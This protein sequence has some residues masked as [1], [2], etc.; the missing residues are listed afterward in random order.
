MRLQP[1]HQINMY[2]MY[3]AEAAAHL[4]QHGYIAHCARCGRVNG[5]PH[6]AEQCSGIPHVEPWPSLRLRHVH[7]GQVAAESLT[8]GPVQF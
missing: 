1:M 3:K 8:G 7:Q 4:Y 5:L 6:A 2:D